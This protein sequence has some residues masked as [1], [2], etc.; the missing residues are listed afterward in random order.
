[1][2][3]EK[4]IPASYITET[5]QWYLKLRTIYAMVFQAPHSEI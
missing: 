1:M 2:R 4:D 5:M 3:H